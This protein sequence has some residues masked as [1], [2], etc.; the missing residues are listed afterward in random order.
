MSSAIPRKRLQHHAIPP[1][2][3]VNHGNH[4]AVPF[5]KHL[6]RVLRT[7]PWRVARRRKRLRCHLMGETDLRLQKEGVRVAVRVVRG[8]VGMRW[9]FVF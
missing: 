8:R 1:P 7:H 4:A 6:M 3:E 9:L 2:D 5:Q